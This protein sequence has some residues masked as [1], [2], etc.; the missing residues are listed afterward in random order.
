MASNALDLVE[1]FVR[2]DEPQLRKNALTAL[3]VINNEESIRL[4]VM[5]ALDDV[6]A[7]VRKRA[8]DEMFRIHGTGSLDDSPASDNKMY[9]RLQ[10]S[11]RLSRALSEGNENTQQR[12]YALLGVLRSKG[13]FMPK[14]QI[15]WGSDFWLLI[16]FIRRRF[17][18]TA[19]M[20]PYFY[21]LRNWPYRIR[22]W[23]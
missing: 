19:G 22:G 2:S 23:Q 9:Y 12:A 8:Q 13:A 14:P 1:E 20:N 10:L 5:T 11:S 15:S 7:D 3:A 21:P 17:R 18:L 16:V 6:D 4:I